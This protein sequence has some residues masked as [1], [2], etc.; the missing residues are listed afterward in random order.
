[1]P[2]RLQIVLA[3]M[4]AGIAFENSLSEIK[5]IICYFYQAKETTKK[6]YNNT[7]NSIK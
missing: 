6:V 7:K 3:Q 5:R 4:K 1:M 2:E